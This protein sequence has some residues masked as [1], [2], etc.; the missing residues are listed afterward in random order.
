MTYTFFIALQS[1]SNLSKFL[2]EGVLK[3][4]LFER[5]SLFLVT[6]DC[7]FKVLFRF[8]VPGPKLGEKVNDFWTPGMS[9]LANPDRFLDS[10]VNYDKENISEDVIKK[11]KPYIENPQFQPSFVVKVS[12]IKHL[13]NSLIVTDQRG[14][15]YTKSSI[16]L[17]IR[18]VLIGK[19]LSTTESYSYGFER[20]ELYEDH[21]SFDK[22][23]ALSI[24]L[25][26]I[27]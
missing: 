8:Q 14:A 24:R 5:V 27:R 16:F 10:L 6:R 17:G 4:V 20:L 18:Q 7:F 23:E 12:L 21:F 9:L 26:I 2:V 1:R 3:L 22:R 15:V 25:W 13:M 19:T 11:L